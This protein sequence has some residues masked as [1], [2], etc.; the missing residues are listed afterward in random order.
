MSIFCDTEHVL[1]LCEQ[2]RI[3]RET[4]EAYASGPLTCTG[5][6]LGPERGP[7]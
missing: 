2:G 3:Y 4:N 1:A 7:K 5:P 6:F